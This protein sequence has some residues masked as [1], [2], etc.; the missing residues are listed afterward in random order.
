MSAHALDAQPLALAMSAALGIASIYPPG[1]PRIGDAAE[2]VV[3]EL[4]ALLEPP[5][6]PKHSEITLLFVDEDIVVDG[7]PLR[8]LVNQLRPLSRAMARRR[9]QR[10]TF[11][12]GL[13]ADQCRGLLDALAGRG[14]LASTPHVVLGRLLLGDGRDDADAPLEPMPPM[15]ER[16]VDAAQEAFSSLRRG[17]GVDQLD[18]IVWRFM[19][20]LAQA[21][22]S[23]LLLAPIKGSGEAA[24]VHALNT[25]LLSIA[26]A[27]SLGIEGAVLHDL[28]LAGM[29]HDVGRSAMRAGG[30]GEA[31]LDEASWSAAKHHTEIGAAMLA[32]MEGV[33]TL[34]VQVAYE[35]HLRWD[36]QPSFPESARGRVPGFG[37]QIVAVA[38][39]YDTMICSRG[40]IGA[41]A[42][43]AAIRVWKVRSGTWLDPLLVAHFVLLV[44]ETEGAR[45]AGEVAH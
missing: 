29:L 9:V 22:P 45:E 4:H 20:G 44:A 25:S 36:G 42:R 12:A 33:P 17:G 3:G 32:A 30:S 38:D 2:R 19:D 5:K 41:A 26:L 7:R 21:T 24:F 31:R 39:T 16:D 43:D 34:A 13:P 8:H 10:V 28:G 37:S 14:E 35:H 40:L 18:R 1:H 15:G 11:R 6:G 27:R 23:L